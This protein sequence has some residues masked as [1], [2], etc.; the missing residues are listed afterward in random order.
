[1]PNRYQHHRLVLSY[2]RVVFVIL[3]LAY[4][5]THNFYYSLIYYSLCQFAFEVNSGKNM[6]QADF[7]FGA[8]FPRHFSKSLLNI[9]VLN[10]SVAG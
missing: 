5:I 9:A 8:Y 10:L 2:I 1:M 4:R 7:E 3:V 6:L